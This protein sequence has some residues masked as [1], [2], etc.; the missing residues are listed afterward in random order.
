MEVD[1]HIHTQ[2]H[3]D[4]LTHFMRKNHHIYYAPVEVQLIRHRAVKTNLLELRW[5]H[6]TQFMY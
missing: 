4:S 6:N 2:Q 3:I 1:K 5:N